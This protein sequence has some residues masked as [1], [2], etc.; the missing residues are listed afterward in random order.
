MP[1]ALLDTMVLVHAA[2][3]DADLH[4]DAAIL[5]D[6]GLRNR[7][8][9]CIA[10]QN[11]IE[12]AAVVTRA[13]LVTVSM[14]GAEV[15]RMVGVLYRSRTLAKIYPK[16]ATVARAVA[17]GARL[18]VSGPAWYDLF[19]ANTMVDNGVDVV[20]TENIADFRK[21]PFVTARRLTDAL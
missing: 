17:E 8:A 19:L 20:I 16:R 4:R 21:F 1:A 15:A 7:G 5:L 18:G 12:F 3:R 2:Y 11:L 9:F 14:S 6:H 13:R 10:P